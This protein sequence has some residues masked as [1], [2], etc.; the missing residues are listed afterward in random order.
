MLCS[1]DTCQNK[2]STD[3]YHVTLSRAQVNSSSR[4][5]V[6]FK[7]TADEVVLFRLDHGLMSG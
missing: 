3:Q 7:L 6:F 1:P 4:S 5:C 2:V